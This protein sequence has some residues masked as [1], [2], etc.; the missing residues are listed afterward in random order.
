MFLFLDGKVF[1][2]LIYYQD[3]F[4][5]QFMAKLEDRISE[6]IIIIITII[7]LVVKPKSKVQKSKSQSK[8]LG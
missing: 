8:D 1:A 5:S 2:S 4:S 6:V 7:S 3:Q